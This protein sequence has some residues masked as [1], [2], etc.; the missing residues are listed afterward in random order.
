MRTINKALNLTENNFYFVTVEEKSILDKNQSNSFLGEKLDFPDK[1]V[2]DI[3]R[4]IRPA[5]MKPLCIE[6]NK[7]FFTLTNNV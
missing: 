5:Q 3:L 7:Y 6:Q 4:C 2:E 1:N